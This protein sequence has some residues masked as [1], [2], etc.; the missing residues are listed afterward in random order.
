M[1]DKKSPGSPKKLHGGDITQTSRLIDCIGLGTNSVKIQI[2]LAPNDTQVRDGLRKLTLLCSIVTSKW[3]LILGNV[4]LN[5]TAFVGNLYIPEN[6]LH[7]KYS[8]HLTL[9]NLYI[10]PHL[11][12]LAEYLNFI[13]H[14]VT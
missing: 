11:S 2:V 10:Q 13:S 4:S 6:I 12:K 7:T 5:C 3:F 14:Y 1:L 8:R 9:V